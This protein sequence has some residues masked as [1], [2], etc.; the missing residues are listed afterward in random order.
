MTEMNALLDSLGGT[1]MAVV[2][3]A[4]AVL[5]A[6]RHGQILASASARA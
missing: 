2:T 5:S 4:L 6:R 1:R 3:G